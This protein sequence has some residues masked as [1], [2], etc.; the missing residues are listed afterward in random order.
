M[1]FSAAL[2]KLIF[3][4]L[5]AD[6]LLSYVVGTRIYDRPVPNAAFP[7]ITFGPTSIVP[8]QDD[9]LLSRTE[10][11]QL[12]I[13]STD[14]SGK[15]EAKQICD[16]VIAALNGVEAELEEGYA[17]DLRVVLAQVMD[18]PDGKTVHGV[19]QI[20]AMIDGEA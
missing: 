19:V 17:T 2:Q 1:S 10:T 18:D 5:S 15:V 12:D 4:T 8:V 3:E 6:L 7:F 13:W 16:L 20:E 9:C 14:Q 11:F